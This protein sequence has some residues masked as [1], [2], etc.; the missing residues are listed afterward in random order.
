MKP[1]MFKRWG[2]ALILLAAPL[3]ATTLA[4]MNLRQ[5][6]TAATAIVRARCVGNASAWDAGEIWTETQ[7]QTLETYKGLIPAQFPVRL[8][9]GK[10]GGIESIVSDV[11][12]F[13]P[14]EEVVLFLSQPRNGSYS[15]IAWA[16]GTFRVRR[17]A[18]GRAYVT[19]DSAGEMIYDHK[20]R[21][22]RIEGIRKMP[23][24]LFRQRIR[25]LTN[26]GNPR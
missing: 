21:Q 15:L 24:G 1:T 6:A 9:G 12:R 23:L 2:A 26:G 17:D 16:E 8:I 4:R 13:R 3:A 7:F 14:G 22:M 11:P 18:A 10:V 20:T 19:E 25:D 5:L